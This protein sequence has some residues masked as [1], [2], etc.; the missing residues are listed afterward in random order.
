LDRLV[1]ILRGTM[2]IRDVITFPKTRSGADLMC[3][4]PSPVDDK[5][6]KGERPWHFAEY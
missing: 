6:L 4:S 5:Q 3:G 2:N 1:M